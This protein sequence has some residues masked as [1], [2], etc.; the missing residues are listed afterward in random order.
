MFSQGSVS[1][2]QVGGLGIGLALTKGMVE[3]HG[4]TIECR[5]SGPGRGSVFVVRLPVGDVEQ[6]DSVPR[7][8][9][10]E[11]HLVISRRVLIADDNRD[12]AESLAM[13]LRL[14]GHQVVVGHDG[15]TALRLFETHAPEI[16]LLDIGMPQM[17]GYEVARRIRA[18]PAG[19]DALL[20]ALTGWGQEKDRLTSREAG[21][22]HHLVKPVD[23]ALVLRLIQLFSRSPA[24][25]G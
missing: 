20:V 17:D 10:R 18:S 5:S 15:D 12:S 1:P 22:D 9:K 4:G 16:A 19:R 11:S 7:H 24:A 13:L 3:L 8:E 14:E 25:T 2:E 21:F 23:P 6:A